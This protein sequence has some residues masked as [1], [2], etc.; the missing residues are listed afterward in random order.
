VSSTVG[1]FVSSAQAATAYKRV[2]QPAL[3]RC[4]AQLLAKSSGGKITVRSTGT[5]AFPSYG[6]RS[7]AFRISVTYKTGKTSVPVIVDVVAVNRGKADVAFFFT[8]TGKPFSAQFEQHVVG[9]V[10]GRV[11]P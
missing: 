8:A 9:R 7:A 3:P 5:L 10:A 1:I 4:V 11:K 2:V 6:A